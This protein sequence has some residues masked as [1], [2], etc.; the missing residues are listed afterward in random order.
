MLRNVARLFAT[1][2]LQPLARELDALTDPWECFQRSK[3]AF[4]QMAAGRLTASL[5]PTE[6]GGTGSSCVDLA[7]AA[8]ELCRVEVGVPTALLANGLALQ[9]IITFGTSAQKER[10]LCHQWGQALRH[11]RQRMGAQGPASLHAHHAH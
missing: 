2:V 8:E 10:F 4:T 9:P 1:Q 6:Y 5:I 11:Q 7:I 3:P